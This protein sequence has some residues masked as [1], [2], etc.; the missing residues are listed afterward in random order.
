MKVV[1]FIL[2]DI[3]ETRYSFIAKAVIIFITAT[4]VINLI[5]PTMVPSQ[6]V[7]IWK[8]LYCIALYGFVYSSDSASF[9]RK[10]AFE[11]LEICMAQN[12]I[13]VEIKKELEEIE[14]KALE[15]TEEKV[16]DKKETE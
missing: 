12:K 14:K 6:L 16:E 9:W 8:V 5:N 15:K 1:K 2:Q 13:L 7:S 3:K 4:A 11:T 10:G